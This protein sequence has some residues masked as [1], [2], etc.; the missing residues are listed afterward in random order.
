MVPNACSS[1]AR[2]LWVL[3]SPVA[4]SAVEQHLGFQSIFRLCQHEKLP[5]IVNQWGSQA[6]AEQWVLPGRPGA[7]FPAA[8]GWAPNSLSTRASAL[9]LSLSTL[10]SNK[11]D[12]H[13]PGLLF[14]VQMTILYANLSFHFTPAKAG[15]NLPAV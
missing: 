5:R 1:R 4:R 7:L 12:H 11:K 9:S 2:E 10:N 3:L 13:M 15:Q 14:T 6:E 8:R